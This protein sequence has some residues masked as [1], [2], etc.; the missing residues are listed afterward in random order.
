MAKTSE[1]FQALMHGLFAG[2]R[3]TLELNTVE[4]AQ[5]LLSR[6]STNKFRKEKQLLD[7][8]LLDTENPLAVR[9][10]LQHEEDGSIALTIWFGKREKRTE[11]FRIVKQHQLDLPLENRNE[12]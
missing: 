8:G 5:T 10:S 4:E 12:E 2:G 11:T 9:S 1:E 3:Y 7:C 6:I